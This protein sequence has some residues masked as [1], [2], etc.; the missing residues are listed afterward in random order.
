MINFDQ[1]QPPTAHLQVITCSKLI[2]RT[3]EQ[4]V[5]YVQMLTIKIPERY[6]WR[7]SGVFIVNFEQISHLYC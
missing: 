7:Q 6:H 1:F 3:F 5:K 2:I 4:G